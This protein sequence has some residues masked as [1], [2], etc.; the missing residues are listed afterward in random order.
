MGALKKEKKDIVPSDGYIL[1]STKYEYN[2]GDTV[3][4]VLKK[5]CMN[6]KI[7]MEFSYT[8]LY[9]SNYVEGIENIYE[10]DCGSL[11]GWMY[12]VNG[13]FYNYGSSEI[14][15]NKGDVIKWEYTCDL[16][17]DIS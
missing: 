7:P 3:F 8:P 10:F 15:V 17:K 14:K 13:K 2:E 11:S 6:Q 1:K 9:G 5:V 16:G 12:S 4:D